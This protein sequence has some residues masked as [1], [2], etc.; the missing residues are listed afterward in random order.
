MPN[1][2]TQFTSLSAE[3]EELFRLRGQLLDEQIEQMGHTEHYNKEVKELKTRK[4]D[5]DVHKKKLKEWQDSLEVILR[6]VLKKYVSNFNYMMK[7]F[8]LSC[9]TFWFKI[10]ICLE[11][12]T[13]F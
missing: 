11:N 5:I 4:E 2:S 13:T 12:Y 8:D 6:F 9:N 3:R 7:T 1:K 10:K